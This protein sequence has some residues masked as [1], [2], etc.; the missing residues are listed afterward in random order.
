MHLSRDIPI[1]DQ[2]LVKKIREGD[3]GAFETVFRRYYSMLCDISAVVVGSYDAAEEITSDVFAR[4]WERREDWE[5]V[6]GIRPYL[7][8]AVKNRAFNFVRDTSLRKIR[9]EI[10]SHEGDI[11]GMGDAPMLPDASVEAADNAEILWEAIGTLSAHTQMML[12]LRWKHGLSWEEVAEATGST[13]LAVQMQY[14]RAR[15]ILKEKLSVYFD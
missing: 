11:P 6:S 4:I 9:G 8:R 10:K 15:K 7:I 13:S 12:T 5:P 3:S 1:D 2:L 14:M